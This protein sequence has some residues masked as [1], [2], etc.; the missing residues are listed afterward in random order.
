[1]GVDA[2]QLLTIEAGRVV[3]HATLWRGDRKGLAAEVAPLVE[4]EAMD[5]MAFGHGR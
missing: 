5:G 1:M 2:A 3:T 4:G